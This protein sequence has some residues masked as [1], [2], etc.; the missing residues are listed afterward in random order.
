MVLI[1]VVGVAFTDG[2]RL[3]PAVQRVLPE[4][5]ERV[6]RVVEGNAPRG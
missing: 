6:T 5:V 2:D 4:V 3:S 1:T